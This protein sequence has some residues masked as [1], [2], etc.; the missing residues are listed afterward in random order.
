MTENSLED[1]TKR[2]LTSAWK[3]LWPERVIECYIVESE[4]VPV[5][6][7]INEI[8]SLVKI[9]RLEVHSNDIDELSE[10][11]N[12]ELNCTVFHSKKLWRRDCQRRR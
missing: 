9:M 11:N 7:I 10:E 2:T 8:L 5:E 12:K 6:P 1:A 4:T 3:K